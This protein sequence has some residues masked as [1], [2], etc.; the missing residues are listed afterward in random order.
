MPTATITADAPHSVVC[1]CDDCIDFI[2]SYHEVLT[3]DCPICDPTIDAGPRPVIIRESPCYACEPG[4]R[5][6]RRETGRTKTVDRADPTTA[7]ELECGH[8]GI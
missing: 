2:H 1:R 3:K 6:L 8:W 7:Y 5:V 4:K